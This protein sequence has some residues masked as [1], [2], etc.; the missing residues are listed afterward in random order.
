MRIT[1][2]S[3]NDAERVGRETARAAAA[4]DDGYVASTDV[5]ESFEDY[6]NRIALE[7]SDRG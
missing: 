6:R 5:D 3:M 1:D 7:R 2:H 4:A